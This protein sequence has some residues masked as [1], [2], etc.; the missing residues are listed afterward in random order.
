MKSRCYCE[1]VS[2]LPFVAFWCQE[3]KFS[4]SFGRW[5]AFD[6]PRLVTDRRNNASWCM[7]ICDSTAAEKWSTAIMPSVQVQQ[8]WRRHPDSS[9]LALR[10]SMQAPASA[11]VVL[12]HARTWRMRVISR[13]CTRPCLGCMAVSIFLARVVGFKCQNH[14]SFVFCLTRLR[15]QKK[16]NLDLLAIHDRLTAAQRRSGGTPQVPAPFFFLPLYVL[17]EKSIQT[18]LNA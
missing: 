13:A 11:A 17:Q 5:T 12:N 7:L 10:C 18:N 3:E 2:R 4:S 1:N 8:S 14:N 9:T 15:R 16:I 6:D